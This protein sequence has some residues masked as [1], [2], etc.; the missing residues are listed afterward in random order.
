MTIAKY[1]AVAC[2]AFIN[3]LAAKAQ[4]AGLLPPTK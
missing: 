2:S 1:M 4:R 3:F